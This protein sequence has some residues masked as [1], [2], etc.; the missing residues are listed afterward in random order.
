M[1][2][3]WLEKFGMNSFIHSIELRKVAR[4]ALQLGGNVENGRVLEIGCGGGLGVELIFEM[5]S[6]SHID[7]FEFDSSQLQLAERR[8]SSKYQ[9]RLNLYEASATKIPSPSNHFDAVFDFGVLHHIPENQIALNEIAR[10]LKPGGRFFFQELFSSFVM[11]PIIRFLT[12]HPPEAQFTWEE[13]KVKL[14]KSDLKLRDTSIIKSSSRVVGVAWKVD[15][16]TV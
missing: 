16:N 6:P 13:L 5:F 4:R 15:A 11:S 7:A 2:L 9:D 1:K 10:V 12:D 3:N 14:G 8:L